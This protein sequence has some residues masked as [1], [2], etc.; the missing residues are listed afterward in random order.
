MISNRDQ[1][2]S[3]I[4][5]ISMFMIITCHI[6]QY[7]N[8]SLAWWFNVGVQIFLFISGFLYGQKEI[9]NYMD[10]IKKRV[11]KILST[12]YVYIIIVSI[13][14]YI[15]HKD[16]FSIKAII[17]SI[18]CLQYFFGG[19][20]GLG[21]LWFISFIIMCYIITPG[22]QYI[23]SKF[24][25]K[26]HEISFWFNFFIFMI[27]LHIINILIPVSLSIPNL[28]CYI[29]GY[30]ISR[31]YFNNKYLNKY[32]KIKLNNL[33]VSFIMLSILINMLVIYF[34]YYKG[35]V[36]MSAGNILF[37]YGHSILG[38]S[39]FFTIYYTVSKWKIIKNKYLERIICLLDNYSFEIYIVHQIYIL[40]IYSLMKL[41]KFLFLNIIVII[42]MII[43]SAYLLKKV[44]RSIENLIDILNI[45]H[46]MRKSTQLNNRNTIDSL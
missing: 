24:M 13:I 33:L 39:I 10:W 26:K 4:R 17:K 37:D 25:N 19:I 28:F 5:C 36:S 31:R 41:T 43:I 35:I 29:I 14:Y 46:L 23:Y 9:F 6:L 34:K 16:L 21:H 7:L 18:L 3:I 45:K 2:I 38:I 1:R 20:E 22:L 30:F 40:G 12:Y 15:F 44:T 8:N 11:K 42:V 27:I 32:D